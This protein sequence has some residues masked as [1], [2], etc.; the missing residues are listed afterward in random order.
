MSRFYGSMLNER[1]KK[2]TKG[3][4]SL[5][6]AHI[7]TWGHGIFVRYKVLD[8]GKIS[9]TVH[10]TGGSDNLEFT[11]IIAKGEISAEKAPNKRPGA[12]RY[13][14]PLGEDIFNEI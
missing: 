11:K 1:R 10:E 12:V 9:W 5:I 6:A 14:R 4:N 3:G 2:V 13:G 8:S 7:R